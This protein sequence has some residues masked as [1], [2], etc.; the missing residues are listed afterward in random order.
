MNS[1]NLT[2]AS[3]SLYKEM[4][5][6]SDWQPPVPIDEQSTTAEYPLDALPTLI[7][8]AVS[9]YHCYGQQ[10]IP[11]IASSALA[12]ISLACQAHA[13]VARDHYLV[14]PVSL[15]FLTAA[16][17]GE[18]KSAADS[19]FSNASKQWE[20]RVRKQRAPAVSTAKS[21][22]YAWS[23]E[24]EG[25]LTQ[26]KRSMITGDNT[27]YLKLLLSNLMRQEPEIPL[28]PRLYFEDATQEALAFNLS[29]GWPSASLWSDEAGIVLGSH[30]M[31]GNPLR[32]IALL[33]RLWDG[34]SFT[35]HRKTSDDYTLEHRRLTLNLMMQ[36]ILLQKLANQAKGIGR[37][38]GFL[39]RCL[40]AYPE[41]A[42]GSRFYQEPPES[43]KY[44]AEYE[45]HLTA[46]LNQTKK[47]TRQGCHP[48]PTL[49]F[50]RQAKQKWI[51]FFNSLE[52]GLKNEGLWVDVKDFASKTAENAARLAAL[53]HLFEGAVGDISLVHTEQAIEIVNWHLQEAKRLLVPTFTNTRHQDAKRLMKWLLSKG[54]Q[55]TTPRTIQ[56]SSPV[57]D[58]DQRNHALNMLIEHHWIRIQKEGGK[59]VITINPQAM[60]SWC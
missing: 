55:K 32:F 37:Q 9:A 52:M 43:R 8:N 26:I 15:Y 54:F 3:L 13:N 50:S 53:F 40:L 23:M 59:T 21:L 58:K 5:Q 22:H 19:V 49:F 12:N 27:E 29:D 42:M 6:N 14:S 45:K 56:Q 18:R 2:D 20:D 38:S 7:R 1:I 17:S 24:K 36:P 48:I 46:C 28:Q 44:M 11:L 16:L 34:K 35:A 41:S 33:N 10:P 4:T 25:L 31:Q 60:A 30:S 57:R 51:L 39:A 47:L